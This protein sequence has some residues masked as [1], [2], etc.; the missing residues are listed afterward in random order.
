MPFTL[1]TRSAAIRDHPQ[2]SMQP[3]VKPLVLSFS[4][5][6]YG[7]PTTSGESIRKERMEKGLN[8]VEVAQAIGVDEN[9]S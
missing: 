5:S 4:A 1:H 9:P 2:D 6:H 3:I 7:E 8:Q